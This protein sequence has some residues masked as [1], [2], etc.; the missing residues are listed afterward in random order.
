MIKLSV[1]LSVCGFKIKSHILMIA[2]L[3]KAFLTQRLYSCMLNRERI[4]LQ[5]SDRQQYC[6]KKLG[7]LI[8]FSGVLKLNLAPLLIK[9]RFCWFKET[10]ENKSSKRNKNKTENDLKIKKDLSFTV[11]LFYR[12]SQSEK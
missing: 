9:K 3:I 8:Y 2:N 1:L 12:E 7:L 11:T 10:K 5:S 6:M 4:T